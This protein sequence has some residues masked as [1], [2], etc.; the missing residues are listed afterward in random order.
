MKTRERWRKGLELTKAEN[1]QVSNALKRA[2][3]LKEH[4]FA[5]RLRGVLL[6]GQE[7][8]VQG[9][10]AKVLGVSASSITRWVMAYKR[11]GI[12]GLRPG[13]APGAKR[14]LNDKQLSR[15]RKFVV[16]GP[17]CCGYDSGVWDGPILRDLIQKKFAVLYSVAH[18]RVILHK[19]HLSVKRPKHPSSE[20]NER[21]KQKWI[22]KDLPAIKAEAEQDHGVIGYEDEAGFKQQGTIYRTWAPTGE[23]VEIKS[24]PI[25]ASCRVFGL[26][27]LD[28]KE[29]GFH[30]RFEDD[31][32]NGKT[33]VRFLGQVTDYFTAQGKKLHMILDG[34]PC[35]TPA[36]KWAAEHSDRIKLH[37]LP[38]YSPELNAQEQVW[39]IT[40]KQATH[41]RYFP[42]AKVLHDTIKR[43]FNRYQGNPA[44]LRG[45]IKPFA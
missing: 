21:L 38:P 28:A 45:I 20:G 15:L 39:R 4:A 32:F 42:T 19:L 34:G 2:E 26:I 14:R 33:F 1:L 35:H 40:K 37:F 29:P 16:E 25:R 6:A 8:L 17:E 18:V 43:R 44:A 41:N 27:T 30:F 22:K 3:R 9:S 10:A 36:I 13:K 11:G 31:Y 23:D 24:S 7:R 5:K 12:T